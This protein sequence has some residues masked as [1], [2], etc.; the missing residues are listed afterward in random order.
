[1]N[2]D[3]IGKHIRAFL[4][5]YWASEED[6][7]KLGQI[8]REYLDS[9]PCCINTEVIRDAEIGLLGLGMLAVGFRLKDVE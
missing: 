1:M 5:E 2:G 6:M 8:A 4:D 9:N 3:K 7:I